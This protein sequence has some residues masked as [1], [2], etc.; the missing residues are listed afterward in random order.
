M[1]KV[2]FF[3]RL[4]EELGKD[5]MELDTAGWTID[6][7][8]NWLEAEYNLDGVTQ[9]MTAVNEEFT[10]GSHILASGDTV[11]FIPPVSGG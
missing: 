11:A 4:Q 7:L 2:L 9:T 10:D 8:K 5:N 6:E 3:A 1:I